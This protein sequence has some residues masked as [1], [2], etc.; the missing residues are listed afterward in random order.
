MNCDLFLYQTWI[1]FL[2][3]KKAN[4]YCLAI[5]GGQSG[6]PLCNRH[7]RNLKFVESS[8]L[9][10]RLY[11]LF[12]VKYT[13]K[14]S[15][16]AQKQDWG[17]VAACE[18]LSLISDGQTW[19]YVYVIGIDKTSKDIICFD[20][21][22]K[23]HP[24]PL[25][26]RIAI[27]T[28][29]RLHN[30]Y[31]RHIYAIPSLGLQKGLFAVIL[32]AKHV[33]RL[34]YN[35]DVI[36]DDISRL[37]SLL[38]HK[39]LSLCESWFTYSVFSNQSVVCVVNADKYEIEDLLLAKP[40]LAQLFQKNL[41]YSDGE[42]ITTMIFQLWSR[43]EGYEED[44]ITFVADGNVSHTITVI[45]IEA[46]HNLILYFDSESP[47]LLTPQNM[48]L[49]EQGGFAYK[50]AYAILKSEFEKVVYGIMVYSWAVS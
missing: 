6:Y 42:K 31:D 50:N 22:T 7:I 19:G 3:V 5:D 34:G 41:I 46:E 25:L 18:V 39:G 23:E 8:D 48:P 13:T 36:Y 1:N 10:E 32:D 47:T 16:F 20:P 26:S 27:Q 24:K 15:V 21:C 14:R 33:D 37:N 9:I 35:I 2:Q 49:L 44:I 4:A 28:G 29:A 40:K 45:G 30:Q 17:G 12:Q 38:Y 11:H 43:K